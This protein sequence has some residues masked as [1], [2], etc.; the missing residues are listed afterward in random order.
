MNFSL[1]CPSAHINLDATQ[2]PQTHCVQMKFIVLLQMQIY[3]API[4]RQHHLY[5]H[6][7][8]NLKVIID[9]STLTILIFLESSPPWH[10]YVSIFQYDHCSRSGLITSFLGYSSY[11]L[12]SRLFSILQPEYQINSHL[13]SQ[14]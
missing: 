12:S 9:S 13:Y 6:S 2:V 3:F 4:L 11:F 7:I 5:S 10:F 1:T 8:R 14:F